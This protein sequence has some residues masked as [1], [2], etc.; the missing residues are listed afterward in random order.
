MP[1]LPRSFS[2]KMKASQKIGLDHLLELLLGFQNWCDTYMFVWKGVLQLLFKDMLIFT[3][4]W[5]SGKI[6]L[7]W[8]VL[9]ISRWFQGS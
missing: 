4:F 1:H 8:R 6:S 2:P 5:L 3:D 9:D 7:F